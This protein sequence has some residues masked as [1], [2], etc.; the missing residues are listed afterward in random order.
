[1]VLLVGPGGSGKTSLARLAAGL[2]GVQLQELGLTQGTDTSDLLG[3]F[4]QVR[5]DWDVAQTG[6]YACMSV[7]VCGY[8]GE[9]IGDW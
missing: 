4:E 3:S 9:L 2:V 6:I 5:G 7:C 1:M 8:G